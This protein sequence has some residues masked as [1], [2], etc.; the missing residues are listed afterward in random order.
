MNLDKHRQKFT[1]IQRMFVCSLLFLSTSVFAQTPVKLQVL[2]PGMSAAPGTANGYTGS[3]NPQTTGVPFEVIVN[4]VDA[5]WN[6]VL[7]SDQVSAS[8][9][10][11]FANLPLPVH[12]LNGTATLTFTMNSSGNHSITI[13][14]DSTPSVLNGHSPTFAVVNLTSFRISDIGDPWWLIPGQVRVGRSLRNVTI[15]ARDGNGNLVNNYSGTVYLTQQTDYG[16]GRISPSSVQLSN[17]AWEGSIRV[18]RAGEK[19]ASWGVTGD[20]WVEASDQAPTP[21]TGESNHF[22]ASPDE[23]DRLHVIVP[24]ETYL[25]GSE[26]GKLGAASNQQGDHPFQIGIYATDQYWNQIS[27]VNHTIV[28]TSTDPAAVLGP[29]GTLSNGKTT[30]AVRL[31]TA[32]IQTITASD[33]SDLSKDPGTSSAI[34]VIS[35]GLHHFAF[36]NISSP[37]T[38]GEAF[39]VIITAVN[40]Q[41]SIVSDFNGTL[42]LNVSTGSATLSP[43]TINMAN[44]WW[45]GD[46][47]LT[48]AASLITMSVQDR[49]N[50]PHTGESNQFDV[51]PGQLHQLQVLLPGETAT[52]GVTPG[53]SGTA[54]EILS[55]SSIQI[56]VNA[57]DAWWNVIPNN[58]DLVHVTSSDLAA[59]LPLDALLNSGTR[60]FLVTLNSTGLQTITSSDQSNG[61]V[62]PNTS[63]TIRV[64]PGNFDHFAFNPIGGMV[65]AGTPFQASIA[66]V[67]ENGNPVDAFSG[68]V[69]LQAVSGAGTVSPTQLNFNNGQWNGTITVTKAG[70]NTLS[71]SDAANPPHVGSSNQFVVNAGAYARLQVIVPGLS[72]NPGVSPGYSGTTEAQNGGVPFAIAVNAVDNWWNI[73]TSVNDSFAVSSTDPLASVPDATTFFNGSRNLSITLNTE[74][75]QT[76]SAGSLN[77]PGISNGQS[78][79]ITVLPSNLHHFT[80]SQISG[81]VVAGEPVSV[82]IHA[83]TNT[84]TLV[85]G[86]NGSVGLSASSGGG[87]ASPT[88]IGPF[89]NGEWSGEIQMTKAATD[90]T[91]T[92]SDGATPAHEGVSNPFNVI[93]GEF[94]KLQVLLPGETWQP[95]VSP[96][97]SGLPVDQQTGIQFDVHIQAVDAWWNLVNTESDSVKISST[98]TLALL[99]ERGK[100]IS[101]KVSFTVIM[102]LAGTHSFTAFDISDNTKLSG[103]SSAF[104]VNPGNLDHFEF[105]SISQ[106]SAGNAFGVKITAVD[107]AGSPVA[108][109]NGHAKLQ[110][111]TGAA[112]LSP[113]EIV[114]VDGAWQGNVTITKSAN[115]VHLTCL[116]FAATPHTGQS[117]DFVVSAGEFVSLQIILPGETA[118][119]GVSPGKTG[120]VKAQITGDAFLVQVAGVDRYWNPVPTAT[121][122]VGL[123]S[124]DPAANLPVD[125]AMQNGS[126]SFS[127]LRFGT[128]G[129]WSVTAN[130][131]NNN[132]ISSDTSPLVHVI[133]GSVASFSFSAITS[134]QIAG[135]TIYATIRAIDGSGETVTN[136]NEQANIT[137]STGPGTIFSQTAHFTDGEW[138][139]AVVLTKAALSVHLNI[140]DFADVVRGNSNPFTVLPGEL[141]KIHMVL[142]GQT[143]TP[144]LSPGRSGTP[145]AQVAGVPF[146]VNVRMT[147]AYWNVVDRQDTTWL[148]FSASD[149]DPGIILPVDTFITQAQGTFNFTLLTEGENSLFVTMISE[150]LLADT[151]TGFYLDS[152]QLDHFE[153]SLIDSVQTA[154]A[155]FEVRITAMNVQGNPVTAYESDIILSASTGNGTLSHS[156]VTLSAGVW[157]GQ[158]TCTRADEA[159]VIYA[160]DY[161]APP[162]THSGYSNAFVVVPDSLAGLHV[163]LPGE[164]A[165]PG[166][167]PGK[168]GK[169]NVGIAGE[170]TQLTVRAVD[171]YWN[172]ITTIADTVS[173][174]ANDTFTVFPAGVTLETGEIV[175]DVIFRAAR[176]QKIFAHLGNGPVHTSTI[177]AK[178]AGNTLA[179]DNSLPT[180]ESGEVTIIPA[181]FAKLLML[182]PGE[183]VLQGDTETDLQK[184]PGRA[185]EPTRQT[186]GLGFEVVVFAV[187]DYWN[188]VYESPADQISLFTTDTRADVQPSVQ[189]LQNGRAEFQVTLTQGGNQ[190]L[191]A[192]NQTNP[193]MTASLDGVVD[194]LLGGLHYEVVV[195]SS[196]LIAGAPF[197]MH[198]YYRDGIGQNVVSANQLVQLTAVDAQN[199]SEIDGDLSNAS[200]NLQAGKRD[201]LQS[202]NR[203]GLVRIRVSDTLGTETAYSDPILFSAGSVAKLLLTADKT[204]IGGMKETDV[205]VELLDATGNPVAGKDVALR[206]VEGT[207]SLS[208]SGVTSDSSGHATLQFT[209]GRIT[210]VNTIEA[211][212]DS[213]FAQLEIIVNLTSS[214]M[215]DGEAVNYPNPFGRESKTTRIDYYLSED[216]DVTLTIYDLFGRK[217]WQNEFAAGAPGGRGRENSAHPNSVEWDGTNGRGQK[218][219]NGGYILVA[220]ARAN[221]K[222]IMNTKRK[223]VIVR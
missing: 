178:P 139:G 203:A 29:Y 169:P 20:A 166:V 131:R 85:S 116:D 102:G 143:A 136:Y 49:T 198:V 89:V 126:V 154:G 219:G 11:P 117:N 48:K 24:G 101:G 221:G 56:R 174:A 23:F 108:G 122:T 40:E 81:P 53:K 83:Q 57:V 205:F 70:T 223:I 184:S 147:D 216:A 149:L 172:T 39:P 1:R 109:F 179:Q 177:L 107:G 186:S 161:V 158:L 202:F 144:G 61:S 159:V 146:N 175:V 55:G 43:A 121:G 75:G 87:T 212:V 211:E 71:V 15:T 82:T 208:K 7:S 2:L 182:L 52:P 130:F 78:P 9:S 220:Q 91:V 173:L 68:I 129:Y 18:Y 111:S 123:A 199:L 13:D 185:G 148:Q 46:I 3:P 150:P 170:V 26:T 207:G 47:T 103:L 60:Q 17:G 22:C 88:T 206:L 214:D 135:D 201:I 181:S 97:K 194:V 152:G 69:T 168:K 140:H 10:D 4:A 189:F 64:N 44:G 110:S 213:V 98:D 167:T 51:Q 34:T 41:G 72:A 138:S 12:L 31:L 188:S 164:T 32:G 28:L 30:M 90:V 99:T 92:V 66:A 133:T 16:V 96:G 134:P 176:V 192:S 156:G 77:V 104:N 115:Q 215:P 27:N 190:V 35:Q 62:A 142:P 95:G 195:D 200:F 105:E 141:A 33:Q 73:V 65:T 74:G 25:P 19:S 114:F 137:A 8:A 86:F 119:P 145:H 106:Q 127:T 196:T 151:S 162:N 113:A 94:N 193:Q 165:T 59:V 153:F 160:S 218:V 222:S 197:S 80:I 112:T 209:G 93:P 37:R 50:P 132:D 58:N 210:E 67:D 42:D 155:P 100:L 125:A 63:S 14:D 157:E 204:E 54:G 6:V 120:E 163:L 84:N 217:V 38:A 128:P 171:Q 191:H 187:D 76:I 36:N 45:S 21:H 5:N 183:T 79:A 124:S 118:T 180:A